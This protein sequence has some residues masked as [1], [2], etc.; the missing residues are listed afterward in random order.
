MEL[1]TNDEPVVVDHSTLSK[2]KAIP[3]PDFRCGDRSTTS[4]HT[5]YPPWAGIHPQIRQRPH[6]GNEAHA[7]CIKETM[8]SSSAQNNMELVNL[9][10]GDPKYIKNGPVHIWATA[11]PRHTPRTK[12]MQN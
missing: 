4:T 7:R 9:Q 1:C 6:R 11:S 2:T 10:D 12:G 8:N 5:E 3:P